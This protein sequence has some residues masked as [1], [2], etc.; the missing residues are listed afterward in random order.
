MT[1][2]SKN[3]G[4]RKAQGAKRKELVAWRQ[5][6]GNLMRAGGSALGTYFG[7]PLGAE[8]GHLGGTALS[9]ITG[10]GDYSVH[11]NSLMS[12]QITFGNGS[13]RV[14]HREY[15]G[16]L[17]SAVS[18]TTQ[19]Y[20]VNPG[21]ELTFPWLS[22]LSRN[23]ERYDIRGLGFEFVSTAGY[24][25]TTQAQGVVVMATQYDPDADLF[26]NRREMESYMYTTSGVVTDPQV[27][28]VECDPRD[29]PLEEMYIRY[30]DVD[31]E[32]FTDLGR[33]TIAVEG[34]PAD[35]VV[36][37]EIWVTYDV[38]LENP[39]LEAHGYG[40]A[41][42]AH[43]GNA[44]YDN[45]E[46]LGAIQTTPSGTL[47]VTISASGSG[48][49]TIN[50]PPLLDFGIYL[51]L[52]CWSGSSTAG[53]T[54]THFPSNC[55]QLSSWELDSSD[56]FITGGSTSSSFVAAS[57]VQV[58]GR[59]AHMRYITATLPTPGTSVDIY[60][61]QMGNPIQ[62]DLKTI[63]SYVEALALRGVRVTHPSNTV[64]Q[65]ALRFDQLVEMEEKYEPVPEMPWELIDQCRL[66]MRDGILSFK[67]VDAM[68]SSRVPTKLREEV[69]DWIVSNRM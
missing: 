39:R 60:V 37:G 24:L 55:T 47:G 23:Y 69:L 56:E 62:L 32:R 6:L 18:F 19:V 53:L 49:D 3:G 57:I 33:F 67:D 63:S 14:R 15:I 59:D 31:E 9:K 22:V 46:M 16:N 7:G 44:A 4:K 45:T 12:E 66:G 65:K 13:I 52:T 61:A 27:H 43:I 58:T 28:L 17:L 35:D 40:N 34:C 50:F 29:R 10:M 5:A 54:I 20:D 51:I 2:K 11:N 30:G 68:V 42:W 26:V 38:I 41:S 8:I 21:L 64:V 1:K 36:L 48:F 25:T